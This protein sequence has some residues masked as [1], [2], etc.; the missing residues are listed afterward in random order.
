MFVSLK[1]RSLGSFLSGYLKAAC[2]LG[3]LSVFGAG[4]ISLIAA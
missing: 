1:I 3:S 2:T 4:K